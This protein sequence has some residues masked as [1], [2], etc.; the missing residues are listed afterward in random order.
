MTFYDEYEKY[1]GLNL[2]EFFKEV[3]DED[4]LRVL[5]KENLTRTDYLTLLSEKAE[6]YLEIMAQKSRDITTRHFGRV[7]FLYTPLYLSNYCENQCAYCSFSTIN[8]MPRKK[9]ALEEVEAEAEMISQTGLKHILI[10]TGESRYHTSIEYIKKCVGVLKKYFT[11]I[12]IEIY[13]LDE[14]EY[15][16]LINA[17]V[18]GLTIYQEVY[19]KQ[20]YDEV[21]I[22]G[23]K[24]D[25]K[26][27][28]EASERACRMGIRSLGI[29]S[30][31]GLD[32]WRSE[33][34]ALGLH[35]DYLQNTYPEVE[36]SVSLPRIRPH[37]G[38]YSPKYDISDKNLVQMMLAIRLFL[39]RVGITISTRESSSFRDNLI[40]LGVTK[41]SGGSTTEVGG[42]SS[43][44]HG[45]GQFDISDKRS[46][47]EMAEMIYKKGYQPVFKD[48][49]L[50]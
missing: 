21:H 35:A 17:G 27:R 34:F 5:S 1:I 43:S 9:L 45:E 31:L 19:N 40:G 41:M 44:E 28:L 29:G 3:R 23:P 12:S 14:N 13:A 24:K 46:V 18:D 38:S 30:L 10:L 37:V 49:W 7:I 8:R 4:V 32:D 33:G 42:H 36:L 47:S 2:E 39:P 15:L 11:S 26:Y 25:Y 48:W 20:I 16:E 50:D 22:T 6:K